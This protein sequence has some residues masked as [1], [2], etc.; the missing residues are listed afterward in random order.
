MDQERII[1][2]FQGHCPAE[3]ARQVQRWL[4]EQGAEWI[5]R[6]MEQHWEAIAQTSTE[7]QRRHLASQV[8][9]L[10]P[11]RK[12]KWRWLASAAAAACVAAIAGAA[13][14]TWSAPASQPLAW[15]EIRNDSNGVR[16]I[17]LPDASTVTLNKHA[18]VRYAS[19][20]NQKNRQVELA[21]EAFFEIHPDAN[22]PFIVQAGNT[23]AR[24]YGTAFNVNAL[25]GAG[26]TRIALQSGKIGVTCDSLA[27]EKILSPGQ[28]LVFDKQS[29]QTTVTQL[30]PAKADSWRKGQLSFVNT[31]FKEVLLQLENTYG[32][33]FIYTGKPQQQTVTADFPVNDL[34][35]VLQHLAFIWEL[36]FRQRADSIFIK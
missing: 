15:T 36:D 33:H 30:I 18:V 17:Q 35:K 26:E 22:R 20:Y 21:G 12:A 13:W 11:A 3:E 14:W 7:E 19:S 29:R 5:D 6:F 1:K 23:T 2:Y 8:I 4:D 32:L 9:A 27:G 16:T 24:V 28:L 25:P 10:S 31:P 34:P